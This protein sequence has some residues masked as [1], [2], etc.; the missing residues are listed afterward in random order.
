MKLVLLHGFTGDATSWDGVRMHLGS[1]SVLTPAL[2][3][4]GSSDPITTFEAEVDRL[5]Q[6]VSEN[7]FA[8]AHLCGYSLGARLALALLVRHPHVFTRATLIGG[9]PGL[10]GDR[11]ERL[12]TDERWAD[13]LEHEGIARFTAAWESQ[14]LFA[15]QS[16][17]QREAERTRRLRHDPHELARSLRILGLAAMPSYWASLAA[18][19]TPVLL[20]TGALDAKFDALAERMHALLPRSTR[21]RIAGAGHNVPLERP[22]AV[23]EALTD[24]AG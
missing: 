15:T 10:E 7:G 22:R 21:I 5:A 6:L 9:N 11:S 24:P 23:A 3:G 14:P 19:A 17:A 13:L 4:H 1:R 8:G 16:T 18:I 20:M 2:L 12:R